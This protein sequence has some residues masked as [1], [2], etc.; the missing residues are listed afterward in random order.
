MTS[1]CS[2]SS[3]TLICAGGSWWPWE[4]PCAKLAYVAVDL[5]RAVVVHIVQEGVVRQGGPLRVGVAVVRVEHVV[6]QLEGVGVV[7]GVLVVALV[8]EVPRAVLA[9]G[10][11]HDVPRRVRAPGPVRRHQQAVDVWLGAVELGHE[12]AE[13]GGGLEHD[14][15]RGEVDGERRGGLGHDIGGH[16]AEGVVDGEG[17]EGALLVR[18]AVLVV[19]QLTRAQAGEGEATRLGTC[20]GGAS[21]GGVGEPAGQ[22]R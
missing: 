10:L 12:G 14:G 6:V 9:D 15:G 21:R 5:G 2:G 20:R 8:L 13:R 18:L 16:S 3:S 17:V 7:M 19:E 1:I 11:D 22:S 4:S